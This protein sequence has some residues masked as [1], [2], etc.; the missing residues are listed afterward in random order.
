MGRLLDTC[1]LIGHWQRCRSK[2][3]SRQLDGVIVERWAD[4]LIRNYSTN[5]IATPVRLEF[6]AG[7]KT[8]TE[9]K[10]A[11]LYLKRFQVVDNGEI[12]KRDSHH[13]ERLARRIP[14]DGTRRH[15]GDCLIGAIADRL[16]Y[17]VIT[18]DK[19]FWT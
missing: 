3:Q 1:I 9:L 17:D 14:R 8:G 19:R 11:D 13:A 18:S 4:E 2:L 7:T 15:L 12:T 10:L 5:K 6:L 16:G